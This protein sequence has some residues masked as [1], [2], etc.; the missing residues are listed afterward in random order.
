MTVM[1]GDVRKPEIAEAQSYFAIRTREAEIAAPSLPQ[2]FAQAL[3]LAAEQQELIEQQAGQIEADAP[4]VAYV[5]NFL[6]SD[7]ACLMRQ[8]AKRIGLTERELRE[9]LLSR[10]VIFRTPIG[11][12]SESKQRD[13]V[14]YRYE[15]TTKYMGWFRERDQPN[16]PRH[17]ND[18]LRTTLYVTPAGKVGIAS[19]LGRLDAGQN[20]IES[21]AA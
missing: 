7:D 10:R 19:M 3:R 6:R 2:T 5:D 20:Q 11:R 14:E 1:N 13:V 8:L 4:K 17:H 16:A 9:E 18:Q 21:E 12:F 15:A